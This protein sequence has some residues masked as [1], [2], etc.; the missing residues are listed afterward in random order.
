MLNSLT[1]FEELNIIN[2]AGNRILL[3]PEPGKKLDLSASISYNNNIKIVEDF[4][5]ACQISSRLGIYLY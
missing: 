2:R 1:I 3:L 4:G 5:T